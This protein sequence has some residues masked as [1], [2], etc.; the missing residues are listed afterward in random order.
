MDMSELKLVIVPDEEDPGAFVFVDGL[1]EKEQYRFLLDT[2]AASSEICYDTYTANFEIIGN[3][4]SSGAFSSSN[5]DI[6]QVPSISIGPIH[7]KNFIIRRQSEKGKKIYNLIGMDLLKDHCCHF[8]FDSDSLVINP[9]VDDNL[10]MMKLLLGPKNHPYVDVSFDE[11]TVRA[12]WDTG[13][14]ITVVDHSFIEN[15]NQLFQKIGVSRGTDATGASQD[16]SSYVMSSSRI[17]SHTFPPCEVVSV[18]LSHINSS[19][20]IPMTMILG[21]TTIQY[22]NWLFNFPT[23]LWTITEMINKKRQ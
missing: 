20:K 18:D 2:G 4:N 11:I 19:T 21:F 17:G 12:V 6:V 16:T 7:Q 5:L 22:A 15:N 14:S 8:L 23:K 9:Q 1:I 10:K 13:A 3:K